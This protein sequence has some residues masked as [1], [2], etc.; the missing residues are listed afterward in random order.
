LSRRKKKTAALAGLD[1]KMIGAER[2]L[3][4]SEWLSS[5]FSDSTLLVI[6]IL[7]RSIAVDSRRE[8]LPL[9]SFFYRFQQKAL[10]KFSK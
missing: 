2:L 8:K 5:G 4:I 9:K 10:R 7:V 3:D 6:G 1:E